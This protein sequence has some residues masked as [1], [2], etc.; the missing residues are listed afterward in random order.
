LGWA[1]FHL[2]NTQQAKEHFLAA[3]QAN[4]S[5]WDA[6]NGAGWCCIRLGQ[7]DEAALL[8]QSAVAGAPRSADAWDGLGWVH[9][10]FGRPEAAEHCFRQALL[11][12][13]LLQDAHNGLA[14]CLEQTG[15]PKE[16]EFYAR[17]SNILK[18]HVG[19]HMQHVSTAQL[20]CWLLFL[21]G[22]LYHSRISAVVVVFGIIACAL[23]A[24]V[25]PAAKGTVSDFTFLY[26]LLP[27]LIALNS[28]YLRLEIVTI[29]WSISMAFL[30]GVLWNVMPLPGIM[31]G[32]PVLCLPLTVLLIAGIGTF[33]GLQRLGTGVAVPLEVAITSPEQVRIWG[34]KVEIAQSCWAKIRAGLRR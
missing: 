12:A 9:L 17:S 30:L 26:N 22:I 29:L 1:E 3:I 34:R 31:L 23:A 6:N 13:P 18:S 14:K 25:V 33:R 11:A 21:G 24:L 4:E 32:V 27:L 20:V 2:S 8:F 16:A 28:H 15:R 5:I 7:T 19:T 10:Y